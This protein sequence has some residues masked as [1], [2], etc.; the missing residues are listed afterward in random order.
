MGNKTS[1]PDVS[2]SSGVIAEG[3]PP[4]VVHHHHALSADPRLGAQNRAFLESIEAVQTS[5]ELRADNEVDSWLARTA[6]GNALMHARHEVAA[7]LGIQA[8]DTVAG[9]GGDGEAPA[10]TLCTGQ[11]ELTRLRALP[12]KVDELRAMREQ[13]ASLRSE[14][15]LTPMIMELSDEEQANILCSLPLPALAAMARVS[16]HWRE[17]CADEVIWAHRCQ[18]DLGGLLTP[19]SLP[20]PTHEAP[21]VT[22]TMSF[23]QTY[24][25]L[26]TWTASA[27][28]GTP[29]EVLD[30]YNIW[31]VARIVCVLP[32][33]QM[34]IQF[35]GWDR[36][37]CLW[38][39]RRFD[40]LRVRPLSSG[41]Q[42]LGSLGAMSLEQ[43]RQVQQ[44][45][46]Q[47]C[48]EGLGGA[49][50]R[51]A[52]RSSL[53]ANASRWA[54]TL[55]APAQGVIPAL[56][57]PAL[58]RILGPDPGG[59]SELTART[60]SDLERVVACYA[61]L[62]ARSSIEAHW[63]CP[64]EPERLVRG[65]NKDSRAEA[66]LDCSGTS[67]LANDDWEQ[68]QRAALAPGS[69]AATSWVPIDTLCERLRE[70][71]TSNAGGAVHV[72]QG[73]HSAAFPRILEWQYELQ[74]QAGSGGSSTGSGHE[75]VVVQQPR[76]SLR[77][78]LEV[79]EAWEPTSRVVGTLRQ[80][81]TVTILETV[82]GL[83]YFPHQGDL[84]LRAR[85]R[86]EGSR[87]AFEVDEPWLTARSVTGATT[88]ELS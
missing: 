32:P 81:T 79:T 87:V 38:L 77:S 57:V 14:L 67:M 84:T 31:S 45:A 12:S 1:R 69:R 20:A 30:T 88:L 44:D 73:V 43:M 41:C 66:V 53:P 29:C 28:I 3:N 58:A 47:L 18:I 50:G 64:E 36:N 65:G 80:G 4:T 2:P 63:R 62:E 76:A 5:E 11:A 74:R 9:G 71:E 13:I 8:I 15:G 82:S 68:E 39:D 56:Y 86:V 70:T 48:R 59:N 83:Q 42:G 75:A 51:M 26:S 33:N 60:T 23:R 72:S 21:V 54:T 10:L 25:H 37:W 16:R 40:L 27:L 7:L 49:S 35:E 55:Q 78:D 24:K 19:L 46:L 85:V 17:R 52:D 6:S 22:A 61:E 34:L